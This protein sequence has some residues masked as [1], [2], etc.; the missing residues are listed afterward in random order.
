MGQR[1]FG[2][3]GS[4]ASNGANCEAH[5]EM[6]PAFSHYPASSIPTTEVSGVPLRVM[7]GTAYGHSSPVK[8]YAETL[9]VEAHLQA[10][11]R[12][13]LPEAEERAV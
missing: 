12:I 9:Y 13:T 4:S 2:R 7:M 6:E 8:I 10:G 1:Y 5:E 3:L 11:Q